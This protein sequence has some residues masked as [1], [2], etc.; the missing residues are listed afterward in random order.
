VLRKKH[1]IGAARLI[2]PGFGRRPL[3]LKL[4]SK[5][6]ILHGSTAPIRESWRNSVNDFFP[7]SAMTPEDTTAARRVRIRRG[8]AARFAAPRAAAVAA[9]SEMARAALGKIMRMKIM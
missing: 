5:I 4:L 9:K 2:R 6:N 1:A 3:W 8:I 7:R